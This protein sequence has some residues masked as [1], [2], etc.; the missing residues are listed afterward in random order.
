MEEKRRNLTPAQVLQKLKQ[1]CAYQE[2]SHSEVREKAFSLGLHNV[3]LPNLIATLIEEN[4]LNEE[5]FAIQF[6]GGK[7]RMKQW[8]KVKIRYALKQKQ[9]G[10]YCIKKAL[11]QIS[12]DDYEKA[13]LKIAEQKEKQLSGTALQKRMKLKT[14]LI[15]RGYESDFINEV[16][17]QRDA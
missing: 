7:F 14:Y 3:D 17:K 10:E 13:L 4:Y 12:Y 15:G 5:R 16:L 6:A 2:R 9:V 8:G 1:F 11:Q